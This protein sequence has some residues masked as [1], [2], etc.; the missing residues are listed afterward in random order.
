MGQNRYEIENTVRIL[1][2]E[3]MSEIDRA[4]IEDFGIP[5]LV[6]M[7]NAAIGVADAIGESFPGVE[8]VAIICGPGNNGGDGM[9]VGRHLAVRGYHVRLLLIFGGREPSADAAIQ[10]GICRRQGLPILEIGT[11]DGLEFAIQEIGRADL[12]VDALL[13][14]GIRRPLEGQMAEIAV[15]T[16]ALRHPLVAVD[17]PSGL[18]GGT[19]K[20]LGPHFIASLTVTFGALKVAHVFPPATDAVGEVV[21]ADLGIPLEL[22][23]TAA[24]NLNLQTDIEIAPM[25]VTRS[26]DCHKGDF[27]HLLILAGSAGKA[28]AAILAAQGALRVGSGLVSLAVPEP[29]L[30]TVEVGSL[31]SMT[32][33]LPTTGEGDLSKLGLEKIVDAL[34]SKQALAIGP[35]LGIEKETVEVVRE[36]VATTA[37]PIVLDADGLNAFAG[38]PET[39]AKRQGET[40]LTPHAGE[41]SRLL[42]VPRAKVMDDRV[43]TAREAAARSQATVVLKG[44]R[45]LVVAPDGE[46]YVNSTGNGGMASGGMGD[47]LTGMIGGLMA[48]GYQTLAAAQ[49]GVYLHGLAGDLAVRSIGVESL[50]ASDLCQALPGAFK[51]LAET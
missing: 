51:D 43:A 6:L 23:E 33:P 18:N 41:L 19:G 7:E 37:L 35:G 5:G 13:G 46:T 11:E 25:L 1:T 31:E 38:E 28:G 42:G 39:I 24:G 36:L 44:Y 10:L 15:A 30:S 48:K 2:P 12:I 26:D 27:G 40:V 49:I 21:V 29:L 20:I 32:L 17:L 3:E 50:T 22:I 34:Q 47:V 16:S 4:A 8:S 14:T 45:T 9:A